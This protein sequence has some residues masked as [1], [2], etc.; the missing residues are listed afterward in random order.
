MQKQTNT[1]FAFIL[2]IIYNSI[3]NHDFVKTKITC[4]LFLKTYF[5]FILHIK[6][7]LAA[8]L[9]KHIFLIPIF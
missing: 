1:T 8:T 5:L 3:S 2:D 4:F 6:I 7:H 9:T